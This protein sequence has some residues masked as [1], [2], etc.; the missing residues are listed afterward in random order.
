MRHFINVSVKYFTKI[1]ELW[2]SLD[3]FTIM[4][5]EGKQNV[6]FLKYFCKIKLLTSSFF[7]VTHFKNTHSLHKLLKNVLFWTLFF[8]LFQPFFPFHVFHKISWFLQLLCCRRSY[9][10][11]EVVAEVVL[12]RRPGGQ[13]KALS[14][15]RQTRRKGSYSALSWKRHQILSLNIK[16][17]LILF[18]FILNLLWLTI[19]WIFFINVNVKKNTS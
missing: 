7:H 2:R 10:L 18:K 16:Y 1:S 17:F 12:N 13:A 15:V 9:L 4:W 6:K 3:Q 11:R 14:R 8:N 5:C 19:Y